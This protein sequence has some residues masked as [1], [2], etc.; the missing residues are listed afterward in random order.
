MF[1]LS[2]PDV[3]LLALIWISRLTF[4][5]K[6]PCYVRPPLQEIE[7]YYPMFVEEPCQPENVDAMVRVAQSTTIPI[8]TGERLFTALDSVKF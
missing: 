2:V 5:A 3:K 8:A 1:P 6:S 4:T 7:P